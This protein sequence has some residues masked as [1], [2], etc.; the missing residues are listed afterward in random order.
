MTAMIVGVVLVAVNHGAAI[1]SGQINPFPHY[2][3][4]P[5]CHSSLRRFDSI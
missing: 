1:I 4:L 3:D 5:H 2:P